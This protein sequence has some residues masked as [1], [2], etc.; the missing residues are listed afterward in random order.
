MVRA[1][2]QASLRMSRQIPP[3]SL[4]LQWYTFVVNWTFGGWTAGQTGEQERK[5]SN[6]VEDAH[7]RATPSRSLLASPLTLNG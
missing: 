4:M 7:Q 1:G 5:V 2:D 3:W 6:T